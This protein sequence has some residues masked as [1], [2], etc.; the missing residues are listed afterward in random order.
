MMN[1]KDYP[2]IIWYGHGYKI[3]DDRNLTVR[4]HLTKDGYALLV[5]PGPDLYLDTEIHK[6]TESDKQKLLNII[7]EYHPTNGIY[8]KGDIYNISTKQFDNN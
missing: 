8:S 4:Y 5:S 2:E 6:I 1:Y 7:N 3:P